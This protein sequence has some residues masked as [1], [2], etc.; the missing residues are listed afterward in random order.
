MLRTVLLL[1]GDRVQLVGVPGLLDRLQDTGVLDL[2]ELRPCSSSD[3]CAPN[4]LPARS[5]VAW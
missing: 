5:P 3:D 2:P 4:R 1:P